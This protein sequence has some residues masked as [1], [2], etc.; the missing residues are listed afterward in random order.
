MHMGIKTI[1]KN[2]LLVWGMI[3]LLIVIVIC[4]LLGVMMIKQHK[5]LN[6]DYQLSMDE[7]TFGDFTLKTTKNDTAEPD[8]INITLEQK[9][10]KILDDYRLPIENY[11]LNYGVRIDSV[12][13]VKRGQGGNGVILITNYSECACE[14]NDQYL[15]F[16]SQIDKKIEL[17]DV[18][19]LSDFRLSLEKENT[20]WGNSHF[21][22]DESPR[23][24]Y[25]FP[26]EIAISDNVTIRPLL[27]KSGIKTLKSSFE[28]DLKHYFDMLNKS[29]DTSE[30]RR[31]RTIKEKFE[32][33]IA[34]KTIKF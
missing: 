20:Y 25:S 28:V 16:L 31:Y 19:E 4:V 9:G 30:L 10:I 29:G 8:I 34:G 11:G 27:D 23:A 32:K 7:K 33:I 21:Y 12:I 17:N 14:S 1:L 18:L 6:I 2:I 13:V 24:H 22:I 15:W 5:R 26:I 3:S